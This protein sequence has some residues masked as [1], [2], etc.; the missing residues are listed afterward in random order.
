VSNVRLPFDDP[1]SPGYGGAGLPSPSASAGQGGPET[2]ES[3]IETRDRAGRERAVDPRFNVALEASAGTGKTRILVDR[4]VNLLRAGVDPGEILALTFTR[5]AATEMRGRI[6]ATLRDAAARGEFPRERWRQLRDRTADVTIS[7]IDA[8]CLSLLREFPLEANL[9]P[10][11]SMAD[12]TE[13]PRLVSESL[14]RALRR[15]RS[16][17]TED[18]HVAL[19]FAQLGDRR[20][21]AGLAAL[22]DH[23]IAAPTVL[24]RFV[25][26]GPR[27]LTLH[28]AARRGAAALLDVFDAMR[29]GLDR[30]LETGPLEPRFVILRRQLRSLQAH[31]ADETNVD[32]VEVHAAFSRVREHFLTQDGLPRTKMLLYGKQDFASATDWQAHRDLVFAH[33]PAIIDAYATY[34][35][36]LNVLVSRGVWR[37]YVVAEAEYRRTLD[38]HAVLD[39][40]DL[41]LHAR[42]LLGQMEEFAQSRYRLES[43]YHHVL[44][45]EFQDTSRAQW[46]L[47]S[48]LTESWGEGAGLAHTGALQPTVFIVGDRK[49]SIYAFRD[50]DVA[51]MREASRYLEGL[52]PDGDVRRSISRSFRAVPA[53]LAFVNDLCRDIDKAPA[54]PDAFQ[55]EEEDRFPIDR[56]VRLKPDTTYELKPDTTCDAGALALLTGDT[57]EACAETTAA[58]IARLVGEGALVR[59]R[60]TGVRRTVRPGDIAILFRTRESHREFEDALERHGLPSYVYKGLGFF[61]TDEIKDVLSLLWYLADPLSDLRAAAW[62][63]SRFVGITDEGLRRMAAFTGAAARVADARQSPDLAE[64][65]RSEQPPAVLGQ[66]DADDAEALV[67]ARAASRRWRAQ[68]DRIP[69]AELLDVVLEESAYLVE[70]RGP[71]FLQA[72]EN[73]KKIRAIIRRIQNRGYATLDRIASHLDRLAVGDDANAAID[74]SDAVSLMTVHAAKGLEFPVVF[75]VNLS[76]GTANRRPPIRI[77]TAAGEGEPSVAVGDFQSSGDED[78]AS[79][80]REETKR[81]LY[82]AV[83]RARDRLYLGT[84]LK[85][86]VVQAGRGSLAE[87]LPASLLDR[88]A[89]AAAS[90]TVSWLASSG[91]AHALRVCASGAAPA[92]GTTSHQPPRVSSVSDFARL[93]DPSLP[94][95]TVASAT[96]QANLVEAGFQPRPPVESDRLVGSL[97]HRLLQREGLACEVSDGWIAERLRSL[98]RVEE[99]IAIADRDALIR[100]AAAAYRA[101]ST[102][103]GLSALYLSGIA[104]HEVPFSLAVDNHIVRGTIDCLVRSDSDV[105]VLEFKTGRRRPEHEAQTDLYRQAALALFPGSRVVTQL[106]YAADAAG[107]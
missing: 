2:V 63:R 85:D 81:L 88:F 38:A 102:H 58:E 29:G 67:A 18:E 78:I 15:C 30:F 80:E 52:R 9:D 49:Q 31:V 61:D 22:L 28:T 79:K 96:G 25:S 60:A 65:L 73:L 87:V 36:D 95:Q 69:P 23:R 56:D 16:L 26:T 1:P 27:D 83:T 57:P 32:P 55:Y 100:R 20:A 66:L 68:V 98:I 7:T 21:R 12:E 90:G 97:V 10:G 77:T 6:V 62:L 47:V 89:D 86:G 93:D 24:S 59:D 45:D 44:V 51:L 71:R 64:A 104:Y 37:M 33:A 39:F 40:P 4:Y 76:R 101:F 3:R 75:V 19:V 17:A 107:C 84:A 48:L 82:V 94:H 8:F 92:P 34:R 50:A 14:D 11:F 13:V 54:R 35:R 103:Q 70:I 53:L 72:R 106:V 42:A 105:T 91:V 46:E 41:L 74:A 5:K 99:S 43:R